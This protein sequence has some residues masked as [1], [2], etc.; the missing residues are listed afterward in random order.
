MARRMSPPRI[1]NLDINAVN[2]ALIDVYRN[3][4]EIANSADEITFTEDRE[5][6]KQLVINA[7][8]KKYKNTFSDDMTTRNLTVKNNF[9][10]KGTIKGGTIGALTDKVIKLIENTYVYADGK[11]ALNFDMANKV[12]NIGTKI[13][14][15]TMLS[16]I[17]NEHTYLS[18]ASTTANYDS[19][20]RFLNTGAY[21]WTIG[22][23]SSDSH[24]F[25]FQSASSSISDASDVEI[26][27][28]GD[29]STAGNITVGGNIIKASDGGSTITLDTSDNVEIAGDLAVNGG[30]TTVTAG[31]SANANLNL[32]S[33]AS[34]TDGN[35]WTL[36]NT[37]VSETLTFINNKSGSGVA[38]FQITPH[39]TVASGTSTFYTQLK[40]NTETAAGSETAKI[41]VLDSGVIKYR[42]A[43]QMQEEVK[44]NVHIMTHNFDCAGTGAVY[45]PFGGSQIESAFTSDALDDETR[46][47]TPYA[48]K[49][50]KLVYQSASA[51]LATDAL[52]RVNGTDGTAMASTP[53][54]VA[55][56]TTTL[57]INPSSNSFD[58]GD[59]LRVK[60]DPTNAPD[61]IAM[62]SVWEFVKT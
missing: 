38:Q 4:N 6:K 11:Y 29:L 37:V 26:A 28:G 15:I 7:D 27:A 41:A 39:A 10:I 60:I 54:S 56:T 3:L 12:L 24:K 35:D 16:D 13:N 25:C 50:I 48:G 9:H 47:I 59:R 40:V 18:I 61:E 17:A 42:T 19:A 51:G 62:T 30:D 32:I 52:L 14:K 33:N 20:I 53:I 5:G 58:A 31:S 46:F 23:D 2:Q 55:N 22:N 8:G 43:A 44:S 36:R 45:I 57:T 21:K 34:A 49:L 1:Q